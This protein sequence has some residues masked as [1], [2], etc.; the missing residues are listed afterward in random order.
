MASNAVRSSLRWAPAGW[1]FFIFEN[2]ILSENRTYLIEQLGDETYHIAYGLVSTVACTSI[3]YGYYVLNKTKSSLPSRLILWKGRPP[4]PSAIGAWAFMTVGTFLASQSVP[5]MQIPVAIVESKSGS[6]GPSPNPP[7]RKLQVRCPFDFTGGKQD[8]FQLYGT[9]RITRHPGLWSLGLMSLGQ[10]MITPTLPQRIWWLGP[11]FVAWLG[12]SHTDSRYRRGIGG[13]MDPSFSSMTSNVP[14]F[15]MLTGKQGSG[16]FRSLVNE[17]KELN[18]A[19]AI[20]ASTI[21]IL[22]RSIK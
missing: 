19:A 6:V 4:I 1:A 10:A 18:A 7:S 8:A 22:R 16:S 13:T 21:W 14:F 3:G 12:G 20:A 5:K 2:A 9:E 17:T 15:A 11:S